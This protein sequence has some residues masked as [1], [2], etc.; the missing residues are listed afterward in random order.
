MWLTILSKDEVTMRSID[1]SFLL[2][3]RGARLAIASSSLV[4][5]LDC[6][7]RVDLVDFAINRRGFV[8]ITL[9]RCAAVVE[10]CPSKVE[11]LAALAA[12]HEI[13]RMAPRWV[14]LGFLDDTWRCQPYEL[15]YS[16][17]AG[18]KNLKDIAC[19]ARKRAAA[20]LQGR[21]SASPTPELM[22]CAPSAQATGRAANLRHQ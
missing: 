19:S 3:E 2:N 15:F 18:V 6:G 5:A 11:P 8:L 4:R 21:S 12:L 13:R 9:A 1:T 22:C 7:S 20:R 16:T 14:V 10:L 17:G